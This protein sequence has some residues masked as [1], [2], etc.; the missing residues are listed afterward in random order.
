MQ[1]SDQMLTTAGV[2]DTA[3]AAHSETADAV[4]VPKM[5]DIQMTHVR[6]IAVE[7]AAGA[8]MTVTTGVSMM[9]EHTAAAEVEA[10]IVFRMI[11]FNVMITIVTVNLLMSSMLHGGGSWS[12][13][14]HLWW[15][16]VVASMA[17]G[18]KG[19]RV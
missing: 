13:S 10:V 7:V 3:T 4:Q 15:L 8:I 9:A 16:R 11:G 5:P 19:T 12:G 6:I 14:G 18:R 2:I 1:A 17:T